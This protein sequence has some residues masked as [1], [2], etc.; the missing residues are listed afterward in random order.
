MSYTHKT[1][2]L[3]TSKNQNNET[4]KKKREKQL[5]L[6]EFYQPNTKNPQKTALS[7]PSFS[8]HKFGEGESTKKHGTF[9]E[10]IVC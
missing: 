8:K 7:P 9:N 5:K 2:K 6:H 4:L 10:N 1:K 3:H